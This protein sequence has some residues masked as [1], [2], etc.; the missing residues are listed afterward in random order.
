MKKMTERLAIFDEQYNKIGTALRDEVHEKGFWHEV[1]HCWVIEKV[2]DEWM[3]YLQLRSQCKKD[4][5]GQYDITAAGHLLAT[6]TVLDGVRELNEEL[7]LNVTG[8][9][10]NSLGVIAYQIDDKQIK[11]YEFANVFVYEIKNGFE[12]FQ[13]QREELDGIYRMKLHQF[14]EL[15][16]GEKEQAPVTGYYY[17]ADVKVNDR[18]ELGLDQMQTLPQMYSMPFIEK[19]QVWMKSKA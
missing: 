10:L 6:E 19:L 17:Q 3:I 11:D 7:G 16:S 14:Y 12:R 2:E 13:I 1:F 8:D 15:A 9:E 4:Y 18:Q 5:P